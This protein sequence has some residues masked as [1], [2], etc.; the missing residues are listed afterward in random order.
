M[1]FIQPV[2]NGRKSE[3]RPYKQFQ[4]DSPY[5]YTGEYLNRTSNLPHGRGIKIWGNG[6]KYEGDFKMGLRHGHGKITYFTVLH[7]L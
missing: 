3:F 7:R 1:S 2:N 5:N 4:P 6:D